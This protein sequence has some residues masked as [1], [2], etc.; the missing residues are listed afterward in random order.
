MNNPV[1]I[2]FLA[3]RVIEAIAQKENFLNLENKYPGQTL[4]VSQPVLFVPGLVS[5]GKEVHCNNFFNS[6]F[7]KAVW[8]PDFT[9]N[10]NSGNTENEKIFF[11]TEH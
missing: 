9:V 5:T 1:L 10:G 4:P 6:D 8:Y 3:G 7:T 2:P 11:V